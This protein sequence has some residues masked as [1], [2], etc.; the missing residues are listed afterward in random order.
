MFT[1]FNHSF[2]NECSAL[3]PALP[4]IF[5]F[6]FRLGFMTFLMQ[7]GILLSAVLITG[8]STLSLKRQML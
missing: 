8:G 5:T 2:Y 6:D 7:H 1:L 3:L 4:N